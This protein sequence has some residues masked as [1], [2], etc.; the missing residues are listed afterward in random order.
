MGAV[1]SWLSK[2][3][4]DFH[5]L[6]NKYSFLGPT[7]GPSTRSPKCVAS[8]Q[9]EEWQQ[10]CVT[11]LGELVL[12]KILDQKI[13]RVYIPQHPRWPDFCS[14][15]TVKF[16]EASCL[17]SGG[18]VLFASHYPDSPGCLRGLLGREYRWNTR[19]LPYIQYIYI[20][21]YSYT[22]CIEYIYI[23]IHIYTRYIYIYMHI[24]IIYMI[25]RIYVYIYIDLMYIYIYIHTH[26]P[27]KFWRLELENCNFQGTNILFWGGWKFQISSR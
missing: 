24:H 13:G 16:P 11:S 2:S 12:E 8:K 10:E 27:P 4:L 22:I 20:Y 23:Y 25:Y 7:N 18:S 14:I 9:K 3:L 19:L 1:A 6:E 17:S 26:T 15:I 5:R 21:I